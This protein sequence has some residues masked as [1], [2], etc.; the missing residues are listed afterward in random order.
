V[1][2]EA[3]ARVYFRLLDHLSLKWLSG[4]I[5]KLPVERQWHAN[6]RG[7][8][9]ED[10]YHIH[11]ELSGRVLRQVGDKPD[12]VAAWM[13]RHD[14]AVARTGEML[15]QM[16]ATGARDYAVLQVAVNGLEQ[17]LYATDE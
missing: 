10:L 5:E 13:A 9:R 14:A 11:R 15:E 7:H 6:A 8:L 1:E 17:L 2:F 12:P 16:R 4:E 3:V